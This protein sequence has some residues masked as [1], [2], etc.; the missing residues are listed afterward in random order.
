MVKQTLLALTFFGCQ[1]LTI[2]CSI[3][4]KQLESDIATVSDKEFALLLEK[5]NKFIRLS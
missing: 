3:Q 2:N 1:M 5:H 4:N